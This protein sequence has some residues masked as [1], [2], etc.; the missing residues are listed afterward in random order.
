MALL[1]NEGDKIISATQPSGRRISLLTHCADPGHGET[2][3]TRYRVCIWNL[4]AGSHGPLC[5]DF[6]VPIVDNQPIGNTLGSDA[7]DL[8]SMEE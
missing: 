2:P 8:L 1:L 3:A 4:I 7:S 6:L 5:D